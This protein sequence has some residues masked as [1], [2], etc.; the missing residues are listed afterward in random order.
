[1][2]KSFPFNATVE[3]TSTV[4]LGPNPRRVGVVLSAPAA[5]RISYS[6]GNVAVLD[7]GITLHAGQAPITLHKD[8]CGFDVAS[9]LNAIASVQQAVSGT[10]LVNP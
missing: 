4:L 6:F 10:E 5:N 9:Q 8:Q 1:M 7:S 3:V 2:A